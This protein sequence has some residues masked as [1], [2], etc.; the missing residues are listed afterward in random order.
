MK[1]IHTLETRIR[2]FLDEFYARWPQSVPSKARLQQC[3]II[4]HRGEYD[5][6]HIFEN[7]I[8]AFDRAK[9]IGVWGIEFDLRWT[10]D[11]H[12]VAIHDADL[13]RVFGS[14]LKIRQATLAELQAECPLVPSVP[15]M[16]S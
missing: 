7:T 5:N 6:R 2:Q 12:P 4:S 14:Q 9:L 3:K 8:E 16:I 10:K 15:E 13:R 11:L 1:I